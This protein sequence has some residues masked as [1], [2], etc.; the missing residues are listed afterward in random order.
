M[1]GM[2]PAR[3]SGGGWRRRS[4]YPPRP[5]GGLNRQHARVGAAGE[6][7]RQDAKEAKGR[8]GERKRRRKKG[9]FF[10]ASSLAPTLALLASWRLNLPLRSVIHARPDGGGGEALAAEGQVVADDGHDLVVVEVRLPG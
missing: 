1:I 10:L 3:D 7:N 4:L 5:G 8:G 2:A 6:L 9:F